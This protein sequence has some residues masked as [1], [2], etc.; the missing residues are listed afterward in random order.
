MQ[1]KCRGFGTGESG[2]LVYRR[3][4]AGEV[5]TD[6]CRDQVKSLELQLGA[7]KTSMAFRA[8]VPNFLE[9][10]YGIGTAASAFGYDY[11][12]GRNL[13]PAIKARLAS[14]EEALTIEPMLIAETNIGR[15]TLAMI[16]Y[17]LEETRGRLPMSFCDVQ[18][19]FN[20]A[21]NFVNSDNFLMDF[22]I[23]PSAVIQLL[24][25]VA[26]LII[27]LTNIQKAKLGDCLV[28]PGHG[29][30]S[31]RSFSGFGMSD[32]NIVMIS[33]D[34]YREIVMPS[35]QKVG[36]SFGG[37]CFHS[38]GDWSH[39]IDTVKTFH[40]LHMVDGAFSEQTD[41]APNPPV[42]FS[43]KFAETQIIVNARIVGDFE[44][45]RENV[46]KLWR[47]G[48]KLIVTTYCQTPEEQAKAYEF[49]HSHCR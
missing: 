38:C 7:L 31:C 16:D 26:D 9:P 6:G 18:S 36:N 39:K 22:I 13:A 42:P 41:P 20:A 46:E 47:P 11:I 5:F 27:E 3:M 28:Y 24:D 45:I 1:E 12:W 37:P 25:I 35:A 43:E 8:E 34:Q 33:S 19:P 15:Q 14:V 4:R 21:S 44:V 17:F 23:N 32:D 49:I 30:P 29:F 40:N 48:L 10:W 2:V